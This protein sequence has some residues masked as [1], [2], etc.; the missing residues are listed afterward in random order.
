MTAAA[1]TKTL[2]QFLR[3]RDR[4]TVRHRDVD[5]A[6]QNR[7]QGLVRTHNQLR[8]AANNRSRKSTSVTVCRWPM[9]CVVTVAP[10]LLRGFRSYPRPPDFEGTFSKTIEKD[11]L[12][13]IASCPMAGAAWDRIEGG[14]PG[15]AT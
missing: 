2:L 11:C 5:E 8:R 9:A 4:G 13:E 7:S 15:R 1:A 12:M 3:R 10:Q 14:H 6:F